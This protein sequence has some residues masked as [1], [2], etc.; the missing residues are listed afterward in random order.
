M[1]KGINWEEKLLPNEFINIKEKGSEIRTVSLAGLRRLA[2]EAGL[3]SS[4][5]IIQNHQDMVQCVYTAHFADA[6]SHVGAADASPKNTDG[7]Y[8]NYLTAIAESR[9]EARALRKA[10]RISTVSS[11]EIA[12]SNPAAIESTPT[13]PISGAV[14][15]AIELMC[16]NK[17]ISLVDLI[18]NIIKNKDRALRISQ[19]S[20]LT[21][22]EGQEALKWLNSKKV[23]KKS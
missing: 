17:K 18:E 12:F 1:R 9:A 2:E 16:K 21:T 4:N 3:Q 22:S 11:E 19:L 23:S 6:T 13:S 10:L 7:A 5:C 14:I 20:E 8:A 15:K